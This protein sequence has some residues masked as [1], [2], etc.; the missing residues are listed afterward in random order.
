MSIEILVSAVLSRVVRA[1]MKIRGFVEQYLEL[2][3]PLRGT[4]EGFVYGF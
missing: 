4:F 2:H 1:S 3:G